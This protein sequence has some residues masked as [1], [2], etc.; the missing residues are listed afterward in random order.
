MNYLSLI[1]FFVILQC[2]ISLR[3]P[4]AI[5]GVARTASI[6]EIKRAYKRLAREW[7]PD[8]NKGPE[9]E[10][11]FIE[12]NKAYELLTDPERRRLF[13][14]SGITEDTPNFRQYPDY[15]QFRRYENDPFE[16]I[17]SQGGFNF[18]FKFNQ[19]SFYHKHTITA[20]AYENH[21]IPNSNFQPYLILFYGELCFACISAEPI[22]RKLIEELEPLGVGFAAIHA[23]QESALAHKIGVSSLPYVIGLVDGRAVH[24]KERQL[25]FVKIVDFCRKIIPAKTVISVTDK[26]VDDFLNGW[27]DNRVR[28]LIFSRADSIRLRYML[29]A[30][31]FRSRVAVGHVS[32]ESEDSKNTVKR[33]NVQTKMESLLVFNEDPSKPIATLSMTELSVATM[34]DVIDSNKFLLLPRLSSQT[35]FDQLCPTEAVRARKYLCVILITKNTNEHDPYRAAMRDF[36]QKVD[37]PNDRVRFMFLFEEKQKEFVKALSSGMGTPEDPLLHVVLIWRK[38]HDR[39]RYQWLQHGW[40]IDDDNMNATKE[41]LHAAMN[42]LMQSTE[43]LPYDA[44]VCMLTDEHALS[45]FTRVLNRMILMGDV[46]WD[47][48]TRQEILPALSVVLS[49]GFIILVGYIMSYLVQLEEKSIQEKYQREGKQIP[50]M[51]VKSKPEFHLHIHE[52]RGETYN[53]LVRLLKPGCRTIVLLVDNESK[54]KL[55]PV[56]Y[57]CVYPY[58]KNKTLMFAFIM[59]EKNL[60]WYRR[61][62]LQTLGESR[63]L[64]IN[65]KNCIG[66]VLSLNGHRKYFCVYHAKHA[67]QSWKRKDG[68][69]RKNENSAAGEFIGFEDSNSESEN[70]DVESGKKQNMENDLYGNILFEEH[71]LDGLSNWLDRLFEGSTQRYY[72]Q[73]WPDNM[74]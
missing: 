32:L 22:W 34:N 62:L 28:V 11:K 5:L 57:R 69:V 58:R 9:A 3:D 48:I 14:R 60:E 25:S 44:K 10:S 4:Y 23:Q 6:P 42:H 12:I 74:K 15:S 73:Y 52:L 24:Y 39:V 53:G 36:I 13:D 7:H 26:V 72:I 71:L 21:I 29:I 1:V 2:V 43:T 68:K 38:S 50:G 20:K 46:L 47:N 65:P 49:V 31:K 40:D 18:Q 30:Y 63:E 8:K 51:S 66:T 70:S 67:E 37:V 54:V 35:I 59:V 55:L 41:E 61:L 56:F 19:G 17:F 45:L 33:Y 16:H 27:Y 64:N